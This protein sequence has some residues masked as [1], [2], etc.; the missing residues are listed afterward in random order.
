MK[1]L[2][3]ANWLNIQ[4]W[5]KI[6]PKIQQIDISEKGRSFILKGMAVL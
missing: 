3:Y 6:N 2:K 4:N 5:E 1:A